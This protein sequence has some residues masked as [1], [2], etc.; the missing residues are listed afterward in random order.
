[1]EKIKRKSHLNPLLEIPANKAI[2]YISSQV[3]L[4][5]VDTYAQCHMHSHIFK[6]IKIADIMHAALSAALTNDVFLI[7]V[8][9]VSRH[10]SL[11]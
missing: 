3:F 7:D 4:P 6:K 10:L 2:G 9:Y 5:R 11:L 1:M 8:D